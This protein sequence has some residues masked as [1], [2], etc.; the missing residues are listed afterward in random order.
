MLH[1]YFL[2]LL[3]SSTFYSWRNWD[4]KISRNFLKVTQLAVMELESQSRTQISE[5][6]LFLQL[7]L[8]HRNPWINI[9]FSEFLWKLFQKENSEYALIH[10]LRGLQ[11]WSLDRSWKVGKPRPC[12]AQP[13]FLQSLRSSTRTNSGAS[14]VQ[15]IYGLADRVPSVSQIEF[16]KGGHNDISHSAYSSYNAYGVIFLNIDFIF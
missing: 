9:Q 10:H 16:S 5:V 11:L 4:P 6:V 12:G 2:V 8:S 1:H 7:Q 13:F 15:K 3:K 14:F